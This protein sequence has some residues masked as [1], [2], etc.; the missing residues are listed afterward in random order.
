MKVAIANDHG[1]YDLRQPVIEKIEQLGHS[2][3]DFG[4]DARESV[5]YPEYGANAARAV[6]DGKA[7]RAIIMCTTGI[8]MCIVANKIRG[9]RCALCIDEEIARMTRSH[10]NTNVLSLSV[11]SIGLD[12]NLKIVEAWLG[13]QFEGVERHQRRIDQIHQIEKTEAILATDQH[14][15]HGLTRTNTD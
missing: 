5:D 12:K 7:D 13:T 6:T 8:G 1:A 10:N 14:G 11:K 9:I 4:S 2:V 3:I 15:Q